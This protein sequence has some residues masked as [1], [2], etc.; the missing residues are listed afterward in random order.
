MLAMQRVNMRDLRKGYESHRILWADS[1][2]TTDSIR[3]G[4]TTGLRE[5][6]G[7]SRFTASVRDWRSPVRSPIAQLFGGRCAP[8]IEINCERDRSSSASR[9]PRSRFGCR[10]DGRE[11]FAPRRGGTGR[12]AGIGGWSPSCSA[13]AQSAANETG[14]GRNC[15]SVVD[16][17]AVRVT[18]AGWQVTD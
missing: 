6:S 14:A 5:L 2:A 12:M 18:A 17:Q 1:C 13:G 9:E 11:P 7:I 16:T 15:H 3:T 10:R 8:T 4:R